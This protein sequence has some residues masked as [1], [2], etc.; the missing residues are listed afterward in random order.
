LGASNTS[1]VGCH[2]DDPPEIH[3]D[4]AIGDV[5]DDPKIVADEEVGQAEGSLRSMNRFSTCAWID[6][7]SAATASSHTSSS[8]GHRQRAG[9][10]DAAALPA[11]QLMGEAGLEAGIQADTSER[12]IDNAGNFARGTRLCTSGASPTM[13]STRERGLSEAYG[14]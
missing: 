10:A 7:S 6:T 11:R 12:F 5:P 14:S 8:G 9:D 3:D 2:L 1:G 13:V 4:D